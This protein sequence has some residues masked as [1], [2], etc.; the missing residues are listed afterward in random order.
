M[1]DDI[2]S[3]LKTKSKYAEEQSPAINQSLEECG[4]ESLVAR[5]PLGARTATTGP[6]AA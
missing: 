3:L 4:I 1:D 6:R 5:G 2:V